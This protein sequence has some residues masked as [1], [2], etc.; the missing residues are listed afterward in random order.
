MG[1][2]LRTANT[3]MIGYNENDRQ[4][5]AAIDVDELDSCDCSPRYAFDRN[6]KNIIRLYG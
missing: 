5:A 2:V 1:Q 3:I 6:N 4:S